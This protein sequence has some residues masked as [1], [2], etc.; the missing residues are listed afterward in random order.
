[1]IGTETVFEDRVKAGRLL[2]QELARLN[3]ARPAVFG[4]PRGGVVVAR[5]VAVALG[6]PL[7]VWPVRKLG[8]PGNPEFGFGAIAPGDIIEVESET[9]AALGLGAEEIEK[10]AAAE[11][12]ELVRR[13]E[14][15]GFN[16]SVKAVRG[17]FDAAIIVDDGLATGGTAKAAIASVRRFFPGVEVVLAAPVAAAET[18][19]VMEKLADRVVV[20]TAPHGLGAVGSW[21]RFFPQ[22]TDAEVKEVLKSSGAGK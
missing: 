17:E 9:A 13:M 16:Q 22:I 14:A 12:A 20:L 10:V 3:L 15:Y 21:Y 18:I 1:M 6:A 8:A 4:V 11:R 5:E 2:G 7:C 19:L